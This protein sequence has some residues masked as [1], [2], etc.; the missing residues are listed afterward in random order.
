MKIPERNKQAARRFV[1]FAAP[2]AAIPYTA[3]L[4]SS[5]SYPLRFST[6]WVSIAAWWFATSIAYASGW[7]TIKLI[8]WRGQEG[9]TT[10]ER[11]R[12]GP[13]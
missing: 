2:L 9:R 3:C 10:A 7:L 6:I 1:A 4:M 13:R 5:A 12:P 8:D 11:C